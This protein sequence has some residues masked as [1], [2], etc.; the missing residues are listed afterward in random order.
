[1]QRVGDGKSSLGPVVACPR[2][3]SRRQGIGSAG[4]RDE[5]EVDKADLYPQDHKAGGIFGSSGGISDTT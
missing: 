5:Y 1:M 2:D 4:N 3:R